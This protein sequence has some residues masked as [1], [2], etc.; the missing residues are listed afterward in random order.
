MQGKRAM[1]AK[2]NLLKTKD[3]EMEN[4][5]E[6]NKEREDRLNTLLRESESRHCEI[7]LFLENLLRYQSFL[8]E[9][10]N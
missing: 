2:D 1:I 7:Y 4:L 6:R 8:N 3:E 5:V 10:Y 9:S